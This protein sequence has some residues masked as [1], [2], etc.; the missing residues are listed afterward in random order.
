[1]WNMTQAWSTS[2]KLSPS[3][4]S[5]GNYASGWNSD[6]GSFADRA[7]WVLGHVGSWMHHS[8]ESS[9]KLH[10]WRGE[11]SSGLCTRWFGCNTSLLCLWQWC[12]GSLQCSLCFS[13]LEVKSWFDTFS[14]KNK[15]NNTSE[16]LI[17]WILS[18]F[19]ICLHVFLERLK[20][21]RLH[22]WIFLGKTPGVSWTHQWS[23]CQLWWSWWLHRP[24]GNDHCNSSGP[25][26]ILGCPKRHELDL[27]SLPPTPGCNGGKYQ[28]GLRVGIHNRLQKCTK[29]KRDTAWW[30]S[31]SLHPGGGLV[32]PRQ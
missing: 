8:T 21:R 22:N 19:L 4:L 12:G 26:E 17:G 25:R 7:A 10:R 32:D 23:W 11:N 30:S 31:A 1:M 16:I 6:W 9:R 5:T 15:N 13:G 28:G 24:S 27:Y 2:L 20:L 29:K 14:K 18:F 3:T